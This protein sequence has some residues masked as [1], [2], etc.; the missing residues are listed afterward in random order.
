MREPS[1]REK[2]FVVD[3]PTNSPERLKKCVTML[4]TNDAS[5]RGRVTARYDECAFAGATRLE[6]VRYVPQLREFIIAREW[7]RAL[8]EDPT[9]DVVLLADDAYALP[10][11]DSVF[12]TC[13]RIADLVDG[14]ALI[15]PSVAGNAFGNLTAIPSEVRGYIKREARLLPMICSYISAEL[16]AKV[17]LPDETLTGYG[18]EDHDY[19]YRVRRAG[20]PILCPDW[21]KVFHT[22]YEGGWRS[23]LGRDLDIEPAFE[24]LRR[25]WGQFPFPDVHY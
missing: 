11:Q 10:K 6:D 2:T 9:R 1:L 23:K 15:H 3:I 21:V 8:N 7:N 14:E 4:F 22:P 5:L 24:Q 12:A 17:G 16:R 18:P 25:K 20:L 19:C 13:A